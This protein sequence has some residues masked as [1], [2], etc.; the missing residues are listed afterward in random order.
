[1]HHL[2]RAVALL[3]TGKLV[4]AIQDVLIKETSS[5]YPV[6]QIV[7]IR[8][9]VALPLLLLMIHFTVGLGQL[10]GR[11]IGLHLLRGSLMFFAFM[12]FYIALAVLPL[13][14][15]TA[16]F[17]TAPFFITLL[18]VP[19]LGEQVGI[20]RVTG[21]IAG[22]IGV[23]IIL[24]PSAEGIGVEVFLPII[25]AVLYAA[26]QVLARRVSLTESAAVMAYYANMSFIGLGICVA[27]IA[28]F[29]VPDVSSSVS[30]QFLIRA[31]V[32][33]TPLDATL[34]GI[35]GIC[36]ALGFQLSTSAYRS[37]EV[38]RLAPFEYVMLIWVTILSYLVWAELPDRYT[39][40]GA[41]I[42][43]AAGLYVLRREDT[44]G[45]TKLAHKSLTRR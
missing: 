26:A 35:T 3:S 12:T 21:I 5:G 43:I 6:H 29:F 44:V 16:L 42:I 39:L 15:T 1:M 9:L 36:V 10:R 19:L 33:P 28:S 32:L 31:W 7:V 22:F 4:F 45:D 8:S 23:L 24:R 34:M 37:T 13:T 41:A 38:N 2:L 40:I 25:A 20:R 30:T 17:F 14:T 18:S 11:R 27:I